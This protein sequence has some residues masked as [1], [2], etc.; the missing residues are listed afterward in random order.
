MAIIDAPPPIDVPSEDTVVSLVE[1]RD[2]LQE[3]IELNPLISFVQDRFTRA[4]DKRRTGDEPRWITAYRNFRGEYGPETAFTDEESSQVFVKITK[5]KVLAAVAQIGDVLFAGNKFP[6]GI[7][8]TPE[9]IGGTPDKLSADLGPQA[10]IESTIARPELLAL[11]PKYTDSIKDKITEGNDSPTPNTVVWEPLKTAAKKMEKKIHDQLAESDADKHLRY[12]AFE[13]AL[14]GTGIIKGPFAVDKEYPRWSK[15]S[16]SADSTGEDSSQQ[17]K[18]LY[19]PVFKT[20]PKVTAVSV[21]NFYPDPD[22]HN[23]AECEGVVERHKMS[24]HDLRQLK[25]RPLFRK[26]SIDEAITRG[27]NYHPEDWESILEDNSTST[28]IERYE[29]LEYWGMISRELAEDQ[30]LDVPISLKEM[31]EFQ[32]NVWICNDQILRL[33]LNPYTPNVIPYYATPYEVNPYSF[34]GIGVAENMDDTQELMNGFMRM[35]VDNA[36]LSGNIIVEID[37][38][39]LVAGQDMRVYP[40]KVFRRQGG[41]PGQSLFGMKFPNVSDQLMSLYD[42]ARQLAD[43]ATNMPSYAHGGTNVPGVSRTAAGMSMLMGAAAQS[44]KQVVRNIDDYFLTPLGKNLFAFNMQFDYDPKIIGDLAVVAKGTESLMRNEIRSQRLLQFMQ[45]GLANPLTAPLI[46]IDYI[47]RELATSLDL[48]EDMVVNDQRAMM[49]QAKLM[50]QMNHMMAPPGQG[51]AQG[52]PSPQG[53]PSAP[54]GGP[55][56]PS[57]PTGTGGGNIAPGNAPTPGAPGYTGAGGGDHGAMGAK[58]DSASITAQ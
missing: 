56:S 48:D 3:N 4:R 51:G 23:M 29:V 9:P 35:A 57:D 21:W 37:E 17:S 19:D 47:L 53:G 22:A 24:A 50:Q 58:A 15:D 43:E 6:I 46:R 20:I 11:L 10:G 36:A 49:V 5:T 18:G 25:K 1:G 45:T 41:A 39:N 2:P 28:Q 42:K 52:Q 16:T 8:P 12:K 33:V 14:F 32:V 31:D 30:G 38:T 40:G 54:A 7:E 44:I 13:M 55:P 34:F 26:E 27:F